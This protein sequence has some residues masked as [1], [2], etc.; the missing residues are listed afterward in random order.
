MVVDERLSEEVL[1]EA[2]VVADAGVEV[3]VPEY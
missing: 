3:D 1:V 2:V